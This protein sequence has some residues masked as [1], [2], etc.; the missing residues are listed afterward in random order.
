M[1]KK[2][3]DEKKRH[4]II[5]DP[6]KIEE[7]LK[8]ARE[9]IIKNYLIVNFAVQTIPLSEFLSELEQDLLK[10]TLLI[11]EQ[12]QKKA[13]FLLGLKPSTLCEK[14]KKFNIK[15]Q[16]SSKESALLNSLQE[17]ATFFSGHEEG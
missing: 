13:A 12:N 6:E 17:I 11:S 14:M 8:N 9:N 10:Y 2:M 1:E 3:S 5:L 7:N 16:K 15:P 4:N